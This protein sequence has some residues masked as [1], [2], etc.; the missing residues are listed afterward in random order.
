MMGLSTS[1]TT[2]FHSKLRRSPRFNSSVT[3][4]N[5]LMEVPFAV[6]NVYAENLRFS[7]ISFLGNTESS[8]P[9]SAKYLIL[10][11]WSSR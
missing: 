10:D 11:A 5:V 4:L 8:V 9:V 3:N 7:R 1:A 2:K 6:D